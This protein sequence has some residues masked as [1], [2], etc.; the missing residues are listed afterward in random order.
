MFPALFSV[1]GRKSGRILLL[2]GDIL[3]IILQIKFWNQK[4]WIFCL[5]LH[6]QK[7]AKAGFLCYYFLGRK[8]Y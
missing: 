1:V 2:A 5:I 7:I 8:K 6:V 4:L 3:Y